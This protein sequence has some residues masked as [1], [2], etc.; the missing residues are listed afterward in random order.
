MG[1]INLGAK[2]VAQG[3][4][5]ATHGAPVARSVATEGLEGGAKIVDKVHLG[6]A[7]MLADQ[8][9]IAKLRQQIKFDPQENKAQRQALLDQTLGKISEVVKDIEAAKAQALQ[10]AG[11]TKPAAPQQG[12][13]MLKR[14]QQQGAP[15]ASSQMDVK[16]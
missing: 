10:R 16:L 14:M 12:M 4:K 8:Q 6:D 11:A 3:A 13:E 5:A 1:L 7:Q 9:A 15:G 2:I